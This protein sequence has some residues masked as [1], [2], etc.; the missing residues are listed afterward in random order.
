MIATQL[1]AAP[2]CS[3]VLTGALWAII[4][5]HLASRSLLNSLLITHGLSFEHGNLDI[6]LGAMTWLSSWIVLLLNIMS[7]C[8]YWFRTIRNL[9]SG[10]DYK[11]LPLPVSYLRFVLFAGVVNLVFIA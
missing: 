1:H 6:D 9:M 2:H 11:Y 8:I 3:S 10:A 7:N 4:N 5:D